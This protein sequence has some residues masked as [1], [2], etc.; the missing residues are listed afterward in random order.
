LVT[1]C[2]NIRYIGLKH[3]ILHIAQCI[4]NRIISWQNMKQLETIELGTE[5]DQ[6]YLTITQT[7]QRLNLHENT[8]HKMIKTKD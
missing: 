7:A 1:N 6:R 4:S 3:D 2:A 5:Q 8:I